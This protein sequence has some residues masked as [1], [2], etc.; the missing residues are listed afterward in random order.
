MKYV[1]TFYREFTAEIEAPDLEAARAKA[2]Q[3]VAADGLDLRLASVIG[4]AAPVAE[5]TALRQ[6]G[7]K[8]PQ[9]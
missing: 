2:R 6:D 4:S 7:P 3:I 9:K 5:M 1:A 8:L